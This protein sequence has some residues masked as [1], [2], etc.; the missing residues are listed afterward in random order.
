M[1][2]NSIADCRVLR[3]SD[4]NVSMATGAYTLVAPANPHR[5]AITF[6][7]NTPTSYYV[8]FTEASASTPN[9]F[10]INSAVFPVFTFDRSTH[11]NLLDRPAYVIN[12]GATTPVYIVDV[13]EMPS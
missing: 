11:G 10:L 8:F 4:F 6:S 3:A 2:T 5:R 7:P 9:G 13:S 12:L 1:L